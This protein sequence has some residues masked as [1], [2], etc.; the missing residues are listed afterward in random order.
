MTEVFMY[1][2]KTRPKV[3][4]RPRDLLVQHKKFRV[5]DSVQTE[6]IEEYFIALDSPIALS[7]YMLYAYGEFDQLVEKDIRPIDYLDSLVFR[8]DFAAV[9]FLRKSV[10]LRTSFKRKDRAIVAFEKS[11]L[12]CEITNK[13]LDQYRGDPL[14]TDDPRALAIV[15]A[16]RKI[17]NILKTFD[18][19]KFLDLC[20]WGP[21]STLTVKGESVSASRKFDIEV[22]MTRDA[23]HLFGET[24]RA[25]NPLWDNLNKVE[26]LAGNKVITVPKNAKTERTIAIEPGL[27]TWVQL[28]IGRLIRKRLRYAGYD[29]NSD[30]KNCLGALKGSKTGCLAT[31]DFKAASDTISIETVK[32]LLPAKWFSILD[33]ARSHYYTLNNSIKRYEKFSTMGNG[34]TFELESLIFLTLALAVCEIQCVDDKD[35][36]IFG[37]DLV[38]PVECVELATEVFEYLGFTLNVEKSFSSTPFRESCGTYYFGGVDVKPFYQKTALRSAKDLY[39]FMNSLRTMAHRWGYLQ[40]CDHRFKR[41]WQLALS[42]V[43]A[44]LRVFGPIDSGDATIHVSKNETRTY[45]AKGQLDGFIFAGFPTVPL[46]ETRDSHGVLLAKLF[47]PST[48]SQGNEIPYRAKTRICFKKHMFSPRWCDDNAWLPCKSN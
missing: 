21:G 26:H 19:D 1:K 31:L 11:E 17:Y 38:L 29:L 30:S 10:F 44:D 36:S 32:K 18:V 6:L 5:L 24:L 23:Y 46:S 25:W 20:T 15:I 40:G 28:G 47:R 27:N 7:C 2:Q 22:Q 8:S 37:D 41:V 42:Q 34:F 39:R 16:Q 45:R 9:S 33:S 43:P 4:L 35:V 13:R 14:K 12:T 3:K 48:E